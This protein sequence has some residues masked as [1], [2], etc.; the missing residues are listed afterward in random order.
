[1]ITST[2]L[3]VKNTIFNLLGYILPILV[4]LFAI[5]ILI[6]KL[7]EERFGILAVI[8]M[9][10]GYF[11][12]FDLGLGRAL[13]KSVGE[14]IGNSQQDQI[15]FLVWNGL[16]FMMFLGILSMS[17]VYFIA[18]ILSGSVL[19]IP[20]DLKGDSLVSFRIVAI[21]IPFVTCTAGLRGVLEAYQKFGIINIIR[22]VNGIYTFLAPLLVLLFSSTLSSLAV[23]L[24]IGRVVL[25]FIYFYIVSN[26]VS[27]LF[28]HSK[29]DFKIVR[30]LLRIG[31][32]MSVSNIIGSVMI[33]FDRFFIGAWISIAAVTYYVTPY[34]VVTKMMIITGAVVRV[35]FPAFSTTFTVDPAYTVRLLKRSVHGLAIILFPVSL[36]LITFAQPGLK[37]WLGEEFAIKGEMV[38]QWLVVGCFVNS[39][40]QMAIAFIHAGGRPDLTAKLIMVEVPFYLLGLWYLIKFWGI[41]GVAFVWAMR[42]VIDTS[43]L[44]YWTS[45]LLEVKRITANFI[46]LIT[47]TLVLILVMFM[48]SLI[49]RIAVSIIAI[50][51]FMIVF[52]LFF[53]DAEERSKL[54]RNFGLWETPQK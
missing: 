8:W 47:M 15:G 36:L 14:Q 49:L 41:E 22:T 50:I 7:G 51:I 27:D 42:F 38:A 45:G 2:R 44:F 24:A 31:S 18:P 40:G 52:L 26:S 10:L 30:P 19:K 29:F 11:S 54:I 12:L 25:F 21:A 43:V 33:Y 46:P 48:N 35:V 37:L 6:S 34:E 17:L 5:P 13:T 20:S 3:L 23:C 53:V 9:G 28:G 4:S 16:L 39:F 1:M 32:W